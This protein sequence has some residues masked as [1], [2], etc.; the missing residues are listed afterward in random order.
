MSTCPGCGLVAPGTGAPPPAQHGA[1]AAC[2][3][4]DGELLAR[5]Y[6]DPTLRGVHQLL[7]DAYAAQHPAGTTRREV[8]TLALSLMTLCLVVEDGVDPARGPALHR[9]MVAHRPAFARLAP[10]P[11]R[12]L[13]T[14]ADVLAARDAAEHERLVRER[15]RQVWQAWAPH[16][17]AVWA[18]NADALR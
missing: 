7:V 5:S 4:R 15:G 12:G 11:L 3:E 13:M 17:A 1:S 18:W 9:E 14:V 16:Q 2:V 10:P 6:A 8:Q